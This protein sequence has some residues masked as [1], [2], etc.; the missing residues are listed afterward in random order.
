MYVVLHIVEDDRLSTSERV[1]EAIGPF[2]TQGEA[3]RWVA[4]QDLD[5]ESEFYETIE[6]EPLDN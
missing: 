6:L 4:K 1:Q 2:A 5:T 3:N